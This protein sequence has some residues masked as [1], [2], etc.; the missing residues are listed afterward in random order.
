MQVFS[1]LCFQTRVHPDGQQ[2]GERRKITS[3]GPDDVGASI[4]K[5]LQSDGTLCVLSITLDGAVVPDSDIFLGTR[6]G[7]DPVA[8]LARP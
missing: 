6:E 2:S 8:A 1:E 4:R 3:I 7:Q 5:H